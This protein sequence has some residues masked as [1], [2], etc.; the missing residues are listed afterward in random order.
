MNYL[1]YVILSY[2]EIKKEKFAKQKKS[3]LA[4]SPLASVSDVFILISI[5][6][7]YKSKPSEPLDHNPHA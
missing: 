3:S 4:S 7:V 2:A 1:M 6:H 5:V